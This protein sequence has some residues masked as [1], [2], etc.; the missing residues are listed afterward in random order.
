MAQ[1][2]EKWSGD[3]DLM[4]KKTKNPRIK[5]SHKDVKINIMTFKLIG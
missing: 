3:G 1:G 2:H 5:E 4:P